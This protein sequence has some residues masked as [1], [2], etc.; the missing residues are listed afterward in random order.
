VS[1][2]EDRRL[3]ESAQ[4]ALSSVA[5][6][7]VVGLA[8]SGGGDSMAMLHLMAQVATRPLAVATVDHGLRA[9]SASEAA[10]VAQVC[11]GLGLPH[12]VLVWSHGAVTGNLMDAARRARYELLADWALAHRVN[13]VMVAHTADDQAETVLLGL[14][15]AAGLDGLAGMRTS[16]RQAGMAFH[17]PLLGATRA[18]L[19]GYLQRQGLWFVDDPSNDDPAF[20][21]VKM[22]RALAGLRQV[23]ITAE[24]LATVARNLALVQADLRKMVAEAAGRLVVE[25]AGALVFDRAGVAAL[26]P[27]VARRLV[28]AALMW[29]SGAPY[30]PRAEA[31]A[32]LVQ[33]LIDGRGATLWG[34]RLVHRKGAALLA[35]EPRK[36]GPDV[37][38]GAVWDQRWQV[39][40]PGDARVRAV[41]AA[42]LAQ[43]PDWRAAGL[44]RD[45]ALVTP[46]VWDEERL[47]AAPLLLPDAKY[48][49]TLT[50]GFG[51]FLLSH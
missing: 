15:R 40:G 22:R 50:A 24:G 29:M 21:R 30:A 4:R 14:A 7:G 35:R 11:A 8:V 41:G 23:G 3:I 49:A 25:R 43:L 28:Q 48:G 42:G 12:E 10:Q 46:G 38:L 16:W 20:D 27:E 34:C 19:R 13:S 17:R 39:T 47:I 33:A 26:P 5:G 18:D 1:D 51:L 44:T 2:T 36:L 32:R 37:P 31:L 45:V 9:G 6:D